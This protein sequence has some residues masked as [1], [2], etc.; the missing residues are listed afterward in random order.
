MKKALNTL[1]PVT[2]HKENSQTLFIY[3]VDFE[4]SLFFL[5]L[6]QQQQNIQEKFTT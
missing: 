6:W 2:S 1:Q 5:L 3:T 4:F